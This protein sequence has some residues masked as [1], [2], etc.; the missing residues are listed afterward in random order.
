MLTWLFEGPEGYVGAQAVTFVFNVDVNN[1]SL[2]WD[3][4]LMGLT[5]DE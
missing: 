3:C 5:W 1:C 2:Q 4:G